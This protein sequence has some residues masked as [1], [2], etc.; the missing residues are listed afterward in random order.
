[1]GHWGSP[2]LLDS[3]RSMATCAWSQG[4]EEDMLM[5]ETFDGNSQIFL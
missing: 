5:V 3:A 2:P 1:M 4:L